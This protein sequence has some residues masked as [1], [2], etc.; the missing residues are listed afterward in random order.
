MKTRIIIILFL[1]FFV[2]L[3]AGV[4]LT[5]GCQNNWCL[6]FDWQKV[7]MV[8]N[9]ET[10]V[11]YGFPVAESYP[12]V[13]FVGKK[14]FI[15]N[16]APLEDPKVEANIVVDEP[17]LNNE[18]GLP[19][20]IKGQ[21]RVFENQL[22]F[23][24]LDED[25]SLL[26]EG[27]M[28]ALSPDIGLFGAYSVSVSYPKPKGERGVVEVFN[29][30]ARDGSEEN[31]VIVPVRFAEVESM[32]VEVYFGS[33]VKD[34]G[35]EECGTTYPVLRRVAKTEAP[36]RAAIEELL[37]GPTVSERSQGYFT[38]INSGVSINKLTIVDELAKIDFTNRIE[39]E[40]G[41]SCRVMSI[42]SQITNTLKQFST[43]KS[44]VISVDGRSEDVLQP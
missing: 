42:R 25:G 35:G 31:K 22:S 8:T 6:W 10:C 30:S 19:L 28:T 1:S 44:V 36:A 29:Y 15:E 34:P 13:C 43:V 9:F 17:K 23:R 41:G 39:E 24:L 5:V 38:S 16:V 18:I 40:L 21:A 14:S 32:N 4:W 20:I 3:A 37:L 7:K 27:I 12:R 11:V 33:L 2:L 26:V